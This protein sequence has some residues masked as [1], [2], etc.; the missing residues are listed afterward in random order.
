MDCSEHPD[1]TLDEGAAAACSKVPV[2]PA[3]PELRHL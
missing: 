1:V 3:P 2:T